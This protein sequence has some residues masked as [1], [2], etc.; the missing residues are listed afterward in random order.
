MSVDTEL[1]ERAQRRAQSDNAQGRPQG[2]PNYGEA[3]APKPSNQGEKG[4]SALAV[5]IASGTVYVIVTTACILINEFTTAVMCSVIAAVCAFELFRMMRSDAKQPNEIIGIVAAACYPMS[6][7]MFD[8]A[9]TFIVMGAFLAALAVWYVFN[10]RARVVDVAESFFGATYAGLLLCGLIFVRSAIADPWGGVLL[11]LLFVSI[12]ANDAL[13]YLVGSKFGKHKLAPKVSP[14]KSW[15]GFLG[16]LAASALLWV[17]M[18]FVPG[19]NMPIWMAIIFGLVCGSAGVLGDLLESRIK[20]S[21]GVKDSGNIM[22]G[23]GGLL[24]RCD[25]LF[26]V[27]IVAALLLFGGG[28]IPY[29]AL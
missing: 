12:W 14:K 15:E 9:G 2:T 19:V 16:G 11:L 27:S 21:V 28:C 13:A 3:R 29:V 26:L 4:F 10:L 24:D 17:A 22:P 20:R 6:C 5:R 7:Y 25:S 1:L 8:A 23:H 18:S